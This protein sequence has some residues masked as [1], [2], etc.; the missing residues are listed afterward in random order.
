LLYYLQVQVITQ[1]RVSLCHVLGMTV[2]KLMQT[3]KH[4]IEN[5]LFFYE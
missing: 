3:V 2:S 5:K 4:Y 1:L